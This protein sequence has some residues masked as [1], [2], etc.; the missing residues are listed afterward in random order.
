MQVLRFAERSVLMCAGMQVEQTKKD[1]E[2]RG[3][4]T[5]RLRES[6]KAAQVGGCA[7][8]DA[9]AMRG[10]QVKWGHRGCGKLPCVWG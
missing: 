5:T 2:F 8:L 4:L 3:Q 10:T 1:S 9:Y 7:C 6:N